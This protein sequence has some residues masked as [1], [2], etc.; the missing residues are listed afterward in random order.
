MCDNGNVEF[1]VYFKGNKEDMRN[2]ANH[3]V[4]DC[5]DGN[6]TIYVRKIG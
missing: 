1:T 4:S 2:Y 6:E 3:L 5:F